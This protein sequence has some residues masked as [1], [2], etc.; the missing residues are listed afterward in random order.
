LQHELSVRDWDNP[1]NL[2]LSQIQVSSLDQLFSPAWA[3]MM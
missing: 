3:I 2:F 1:A